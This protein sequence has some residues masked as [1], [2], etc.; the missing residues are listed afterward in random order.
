MALLQASH[1]LA[2]DVSILEYSMELDR[3]PLVL[4]HGRNGFLF[5]CFVLTVLGYGGTNFI[6]LFYFYLPLCLLKTP[7]YGP[8]SAA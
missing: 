6:Y 4:S 8:S 3:I 2:T 1:D 7:L 5:Y